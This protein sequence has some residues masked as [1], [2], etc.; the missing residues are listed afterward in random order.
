MLPKLPILP[1]LALAFLLLFPL[2]ASAC[3]SNKPSATF[4]TPAVQQV[5]SCFHKP[6]S[7]AF[8]LDGKY[9]FVTNCASG[10]YGPTATFGLVPT[11]GAVSKLS[12][13]KDGQLKLLAQR[14]AD[15]LTAPLGISVLPKA[16]RRLPA[17]TLFVNVGFYLQC[18]EDGR[19]ISDPSQWGTGILLLHPKTGKRLG[20]IACGID[21]PLAKALNRPMFGLNGS[22]F[23]SQGNFYT[24]ECGGGASIV[25]AANFPDEPGILRLNHDAL[26]DLVA[27]RADPKQIAFQ[28]L[29]AGP[30][31]LF[32][33][34][35]AAALYVATSGSSQAAGGPIYALPINSF[36]TDTLPPPV[37]D[38]LA[39]LDGIAITPAGSI[40][41]SRMKGDL[42]IIPPSQSAKP[43][44]LVP[45]TL[46]RSPSD[47]K[48]RPLS[49][50]S[51]LLVVPEQDSQ[52]TKPWTQ[53]IWIISLP[54][55]QSPPQP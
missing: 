24:A 23:D 16:T 49:D 36:P 1:A 38:G 55:E 28:I 33:S 32:F 46:F 5:F 25:P 50:G 17:G 3:S 35:T 11:K 45:P 48:L 52:A 40:I 12:V 26:D 14:W 44:R 39:P 2:F 22:A 54:K 34:P 19:T 43:L 18:D 51:C 7:C 29:P 42:I 30:N 20:M 9:L 21:S 41:A 47:I 15:G 13:S 53:R 31:G 4:T 6:E 37:A 27:G 10:R 8:S